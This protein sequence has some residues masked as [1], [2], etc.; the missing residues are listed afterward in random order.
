MTL[1]YVF[2]ACPD[3]H[4]GHTSGY[5]QLVCQQGGFI[6]P[7]PMGFSAGLDKIY[8]YEVLRKSG[9]APVHSIPALHRFSEVYLGSYIDVE[10]L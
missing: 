7:L 2:T 8:Q 4:L 5:E 3:A 6:V 1:T 10:Y 9:H